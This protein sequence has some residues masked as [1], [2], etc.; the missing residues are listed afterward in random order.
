[1]VYSCSHYV[2]SYCWIFLD[3]KVF[4]LLLPLLLSSTS[5]SRNRLLSLLSAFLLWYLLS[6]ELD[7]HDHLVG[8]DF[9]AFVIFH[10]P[11]SLPPH[12]LPTTRPTTPQSTSCVTHTILLFAPTIVTDPLF[13][14]PPIHK[15]LLDQ[16]PKKGTGLGGSRSSPRSRPPPAWLRNSCLSCSL[17]LSDFLLPQTLSKRGAIALGRYLL[18]ER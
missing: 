18:L 7:L 5:Y 12:F 8:K 4:L 16:I 9:P 2:I 3:L 13:P 17:L 11:S 14:P 6:T 15:P 1:M 10:I